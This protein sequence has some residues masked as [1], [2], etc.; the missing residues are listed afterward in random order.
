MEQTL[1]IFS[2]IQINSY[3]PTRT[4]VL[5]NVYAKAM[6]K[7]FDELTLM[8][9]RSVLD[10]DCFGLKKIPMVVQQ[11]K[12]T[13][14]QQFAFAS[15]AAK[16]EEFMKWLQEQIDK[17]ILD[18]R[19]LEQIGDSVNSNWQNMYLFDSYKRGIIRARYEM[20]KVGLDISTIEDS[21]GIDMVMSLPFH[22]DRIGLIYI[23]AYNELKGI[24]DAMSQQIS[25]VLAQGL[26]DGDGPA[27]LARKLV[28]TINGTGMGELG[29]TDT[30]GRF[31][32]AKRRADMLAR[33]ETIRAHH[34]ANIAEYRSWGVLG[35]S[36]QAEWRTAGDDRVCEKC[37]SLH[38]K[39]FTLDEIEPMI[40]L[41]PLCRCF[42]LPHIEKL[43]KYK[44]KKS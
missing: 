28:S 3:D 6:A 7:K 35:V 9:K 39:R 43:E 26:A 18:V 41:H 24:T 16:V 11:M 5:R 8:V 38:G 1:T 19:T 30:L 33:T 31:I 29:I 17:G 36:V 40:P 22:I 42:A 23:R 21:G 25:R 44:T 14:S 15:S 12:P 13:G 2:D 4:T 20:R 34:L 27:L 10:Q 37:A 32:P